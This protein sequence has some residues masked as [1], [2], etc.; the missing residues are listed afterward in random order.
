MIIDRECGEAH[1]CHRVSKQ[2][3]YH[4]SQVILG[5]I[6]SVSGDDNLNKQNPPSLRT[7]PEGF[8][9][10]PPE[11][12]IGIEL[13]DCKFCPPVRSKVLHVCDRVKG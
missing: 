11:F 6:E 10:P 13:Q 1:T 2:A 4:S 3:P 8:V 12:W 7:S 5:V 9:R